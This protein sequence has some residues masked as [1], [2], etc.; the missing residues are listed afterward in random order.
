MTRVE[1]KP[2]L[3]VHG[4]WM[5]PA[6]TVPLARSLRA[7]GFDATPFGYGS[8]RGDPDESAAKLVTRLRDGAVQSMV[9]HSLGGLIALKALARAPEL[10]AGRLVLL[11]CPVR[12][13]RVSMR[14]ASWPGGGRALG[15]ARSLLAEPQG[16]GAG[17][18]QVGQIAGTR[19]VGLG[20]LAGG[21]TRPSDGSVFVEE[22]C[23]D[24]LTDHLALPVS[25]FG[26]LFSR[27]VAKAAAEFLDRGRFG[28]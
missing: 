21:A 4:L 3:L 13:S 12:G 11:G 24:F 22:T 26:M 27:R 9:A 19:R 2:V 8:V 10:A 15:A 5:T 6:A 1:A 23:E 7:H 14:F 20:V 25:H 18:W 28:G 17:S 16:L